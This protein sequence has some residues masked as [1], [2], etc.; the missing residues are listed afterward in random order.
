MEVI[1]PD[2]LKDKDLYF[3]TFYEMTPNFSSHEHAWSA[4]EDI[5]EDNYD[6][7]VYSNY[8]SFKSAKSRYKKKA[9]TK[10]RHRF[11]IFK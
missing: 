2:I 3:R 10:S 1:T 9:K 8:N 7:R 4:L 6:T 5:I 11:Q